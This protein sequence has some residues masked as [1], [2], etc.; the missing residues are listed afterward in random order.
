MSYDHV[1]WAQPLVHEVP[2][3]CCKTVG[4]AFGGLKER[5]AMLG[6][7]VA[8]SL[9][10]SKNILRIEGSILRPR[11]LTLHNVFGELGSCSGWDFAAGWFAWQYFCL[12]TQHFGFWSEGGYTHRCE[13]LLVGPAT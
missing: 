8:A 6:P 10:G 5:R 12:R 4:K 7:V 11:R 1:E 9:K 2:N 13:Y 3:L